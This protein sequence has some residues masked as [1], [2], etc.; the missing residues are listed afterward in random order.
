DEEKTLAESYDA[1]RC[2]A[3]A[4]RL[5]KNGTWMVPTITVLRST[6][7]LDDTTLGSDPRLAYIP[8]FFSDSWN[9]AKDF[10]FRA[11]TAQDWLARK[12][13]FDEQL[14]IARLLH[15]AGVQF[16]AGTDLSNPYIYP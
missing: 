16:L 7:Y 4:A 5:K 11:L 6:A 3:L 2:R 14:K 13:L 1:D 8:T 9:P 12:A 10:R 15:D